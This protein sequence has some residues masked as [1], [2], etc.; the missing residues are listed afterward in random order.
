MPQSTL[1]KNYLERAS[2]N[3]HSLPPPQKVNVAT[4][5]KLVRGSAHV[6]KTNLLFAQNTVA[7]TQTGKNANPSKKRNGYGIQADIP[8]GVGFKFVPPEK[9][10]IPNTSLF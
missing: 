8:K 1:C 7:T 2:F 4:V 10:M 5:G 9:T 3:P 6:N